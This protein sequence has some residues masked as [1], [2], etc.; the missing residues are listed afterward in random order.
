[1]AT[2]A[3]AAVASERIEINET[4]ALTLVFLLVEFHDVNRAAKGRADTLIRHLKVTGTW[5][6]N[7]VHPSGRLDSQGRLKLTE[8]KI[9]LTAQHLYNKM[10][11]CDAH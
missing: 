11:H 9:S 3:K 6:E 10:P 1:M 2:A 8:I 4:S 7:N 5:L